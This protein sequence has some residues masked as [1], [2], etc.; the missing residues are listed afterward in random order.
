MPDKFKKVSARIPVH[1]LEKLEEMGISNQTEA[2]IKGLERLTAEDN[3][4][5]KEDS[6]KTA[7]LQAKVEE[8]QAHKETLKKEHEDFKAMH[9]N[10]MLQ[11]QTLIQQKAIEAPGAKKP[12][13]KFW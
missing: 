4:K 7:V 5:T 12:W 2:I 9:N 8:L 10:Y 6:E 3:E 13:W 11:V 1:L